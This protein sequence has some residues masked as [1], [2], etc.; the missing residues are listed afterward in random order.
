MRLFASAFGVLLFAFGVFAGSA[1]A[2]KPKIN[3]S[4]G[5][6]EH[7]V[8]ATG[9]IGKGKLQGAPPRKR[10][11]AILLEDSADDGTW[12]PVDSAKLAQGKNFALRW[13]APDSLDSASV[14]IKLKAGKKSIQ[15]Q[16]ERLSFG[17]DPGDPI[18]DAVDPADV[19]SLPTVSDPTLR[20]AGS[21]NLEPGQ[22][23]A[24]PPE[25][26]TPD[27]FLLKVASSSV[28]GDQ[29]LVETEPASLYEAVPTG[30]I[31]VNLG[32]LSSAEPLNA[33]ARAFSQ[34]MRQGDDSEAN[35]P[36]SEQVS[37]TGAGQ[38]SLSGSLDASLEPDLDLEWSKRF[39]IPPVDDRPGPRNR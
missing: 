23:L 3:V 6:D 11:R 33:D 31:A 26:N 37:C 24:A 13:S 21:Q 1:Q 39:G 35:V 4:Y 38:M 5:V 32:D 29:T 12:A 10:W 14:R 27:G 30:Q 34:S 7:Q 25:G 2:A 15:S 16:A 17:T 9:T 28:S 22:F 19:V 20:L 8:D 18:V 36:F